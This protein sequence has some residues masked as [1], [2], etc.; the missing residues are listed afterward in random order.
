MNLSDI[1]L[2]YDYNDWANRLIL[3]QSALVT[4]DQFIAAPCFK[5]IM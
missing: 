1:K 3:D 5:A 4:P 2:I